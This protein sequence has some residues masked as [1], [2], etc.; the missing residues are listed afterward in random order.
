MRQRKPPCSPPP[1]QAQIARINGVFGGS[2]TGKTA[3]VIKQIK[4]DKPDRLFIWDTLG[5]FAKK[6][7]GTACFTMLD[8]AVWTAG[9][10]YA[11]AYQPKGDEK[12]MRKQ[13]DMFCKIAF[14]AGQHGPVTFVAEELTDVTNASHALEGWR[15]VSVM[16]RHRGFTVYGMSQS[17]AWV[18]KRFT[19]NC[20]KVR[21]G[22]LVEVPHA[23]RMSETLG[24][25]YR[26]IMELP[27]LH[28]I[29]KDMRTGAVERG[30]L[31][32]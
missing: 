16:G 17:P 28:Y 29:E 6:G 5:E 30:V 15:R 25:P 2:G 3:Y 31:T 21:T 14:A 26:K 9:R 7:M 24:V 32:F 4:A 27:D 20:T 19:G 18:D 12:A 10:R 8:V 22:R 23:K 13:F 1:E 11:I